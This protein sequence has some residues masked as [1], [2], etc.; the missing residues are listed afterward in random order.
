MAARLEQ[1]AD[2]AAT[3]GRHLTAGNYY[4]RAG[5]YYF[6]GERMVPPGEQK[7]GIYR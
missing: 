5:N 7:L 2:A 6:T 3:E 1:T 4:I